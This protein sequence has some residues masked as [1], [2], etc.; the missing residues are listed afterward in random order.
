MKKLLILVAGVMMLVVAGCN[1][2]CPMTVAPKPPVADVEKKGPLGLSQE[3]MKALFSKD[4]VELS[5]S[6]KQRIISKSKQLKLTPEEMQVLKSTG[7][8]ILCGKCGY[9]LNEK[10]FQEFEKGKV[11]NVDK[12]TGFAADSLR[13]RI[14]KKN[15][16]D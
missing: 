6:L 15:L 10:K 4:N 1:S 3:E 16:E 8:V 14:I 12:N 13:E 7:K 9:L 2:S 5:D 11:I